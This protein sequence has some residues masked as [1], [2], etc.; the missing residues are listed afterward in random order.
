MNRSAQDHHFSLFP[1]I[2][3]Q[4]PV[5]RTPDNSNLFPFPLKV[6]VVGSRL[7]MGKSWRLLLPL[8]ISLFQTA[9]K[10]SSNYSKNPMSPEPF[11]SAAKAL[12]AKRSEKGYGDENGA[13]SRR[14]PSSRFPPS[15]KGGS[16]AERAYPQCKS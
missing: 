5:T 4:L 11:V 1:V 16:A 12:P 14:P 13:T 2:R 3:S 8:K 15:T 10:K 7:Y 6:R 9:N